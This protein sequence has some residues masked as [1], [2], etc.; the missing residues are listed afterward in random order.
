MPKEVPLPQT[1]RKKLNPAEAAWVKDQSGDE[2]LHMADLLREASIMEVA[3][4]GAPPAGWE[5][6]VESCGGCLGQ[7]E[8]RR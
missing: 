4:R 5:D 6:K 8:V 1:G 7:S 3:Q 2:A